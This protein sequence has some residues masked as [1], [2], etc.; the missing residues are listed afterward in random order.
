MTPSEERACYE[1]AAKA[2][3]LTRHDVNADGSNWARGYKAGQRNCAA[4]IRALPLTT[5]SAATQEVRLDPSQSAQSGKG[6][7]TG[8]RPEVLSASAADPIQAHSKSQ[9]NRLVTQGANVT[10][11]AQSSTAADD[12]QLEYVEGI[13]VG[14]SGQGAAPLEPVGWIPIS[15]LPKR[16]GTYI[17]G[18]YRDEEPKAFDWGFAFFVRLEFGSEWHEKEEHLNFPIQYWFELP[19]HPRYAMLAAG[20]V[21]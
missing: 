6:D 11:P 1:R 8:V 18:G 14:I 17:V 3:E 20:R 9:Y 21:K 16:G 12:R 10:A 13:A 5:E 7:S 19:P 15:T 2:C 4:A